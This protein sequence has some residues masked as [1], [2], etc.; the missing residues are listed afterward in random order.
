[1]PWSPME[2]MSDDRT[3]YDE[4]YPSRRLLDVIGDKWKPI[5]L[6]IL[7][8]GMKRYGELHRHLPDVS[9][10]MLTQ[11]LRVLESDGLLQRTVYAEVPPK[12]EYDLTPLGRSFLSPVMSLCRWASSHTADLDAV[13]SCRKKSL[14]RERTPPADK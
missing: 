7:G 3:V 6:L 14:R 8:H 12:V 2:A 4:N 1:V 5:V 10:K 9:K 13:Q 11:T